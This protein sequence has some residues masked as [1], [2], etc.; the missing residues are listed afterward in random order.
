MKYYNKDAKEL[1]PLL[2]PSPVPNLHQQKYRVKE[3]FIQSGVN[4]INSPKNKVY[5]CKFKQNGRFV[6][7]LDGKGNECLGV[8]HNTANG[9][10]LYISIDKNDNDTFL[11]TPTILSENNDVIEMDGVIIESGTSAGNV[12]KIVDTIYDVMPSTLKTKMKDFYNKINTS[13]RKKTDQNVGVAY[14]TCKRVD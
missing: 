2:S 13:L 11:Y 14:M 8:W 10:Q 5:T 3:S 12:L 4:K 9:W 1:D 7:S 6:S